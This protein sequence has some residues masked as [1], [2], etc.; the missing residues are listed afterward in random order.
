MRPYDIKILYNNNVYCGLK[1]YVRYILLRCI[2][3]LTH[4]IKSSDS[5]LA[6]V[7]N[8]L[9]NSKILFV[10]KYIDLDC[11]H[12]KSDNKIIRC[13]SLY[14]GICNFYKLK[15]DNEHNLFNIH[16]ITK[17]YFKSHN[18]N[19]N[20]LPKLINYVGYNN[21]FIDVIK[22][23]YISG[24]DD[25]LCI[26]LMINLFD[27]KTYEIIIH[28]IDENKNIENILEE[29]AELNDKSNKSD[30]FCINKKWFIG[31]T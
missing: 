23:E 13:S 2:Y 12:F 19:K 14:D 10:K 24:C 1:L 22:M 9:I 7:L 18:K 25:I 26:E 29:M 3:V 21:K 5:F 28:Q 31:D 27:V 8:K 20:I 6:S 17:I 4:A 30:N 15:N 11:S 16:K